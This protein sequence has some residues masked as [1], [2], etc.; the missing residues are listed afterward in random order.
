M[1]YCEAYVQKLDYDEYVA[2]KRRINGVM[3]KQ[4]MLLKEQYEAEHANGYCPIC[5]CLR[6]ANGKCMNGCED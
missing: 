6:A 4:D 2:N 1:D 3:R 5:H